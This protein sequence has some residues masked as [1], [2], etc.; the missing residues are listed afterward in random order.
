MH[1]FKMLLSKIEKLILIYK[2]LNISVFRNKQE[3]YYKKC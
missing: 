1:L 2:V 3:V